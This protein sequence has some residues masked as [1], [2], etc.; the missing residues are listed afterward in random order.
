VCG[1]SNP[2][3]LDANESTWA[4]TAGSCD[5]RATNPQ[6]RLLA[7]TVTKSCGK[8]CCGLAADWPAGVIS[9]A[10]RSRPLDFAIPLCRHDIAL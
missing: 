8:F 5:G 10:I 9:P 1:D 3:L 4:L 6:V 2:D 7:V